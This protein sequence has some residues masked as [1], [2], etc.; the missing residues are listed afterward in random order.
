MFT[1][2]RLLII[3]MKIIWTSRRVEVYNDGKSW[4]YRAL[5]KKLTIY[6]VGI[7]KDTFRISFWLSNKAEP[8][9]ESSDLPERIKE[10]FRS[11]RD[12]IPPDVF[13]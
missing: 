3:C 5:R 9:V 11:Q 13:Q 1:G 8:L 2:S 6:W 7:L 10:E 12:L 4:L